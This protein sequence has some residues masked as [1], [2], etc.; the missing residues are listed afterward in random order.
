MLRIL[1]RQSDCARSIPPHSCKPAGSDCSVIVAD[2]SGC[3]RHKHRRQS[4]QELRQS[5]VVHPAL[6]LRFAE[7]AR[8]FDNESRTRRWRFAGIQT[9]PSSLPAFRSVLLPHAARVMDKVTVIRSVT[10]P[11]PIHGVAFATTG[12]PT[13]D[14]PME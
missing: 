14:V 3:N 8:T 1:V 10:H 9:D 7:P 5:Q 13:I 11:Y 2:S 4:C 6:S 12:V